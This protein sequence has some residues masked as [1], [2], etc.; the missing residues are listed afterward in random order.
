MR[1]EAVNCQHNKL[2]NSLCGY[3]QKSSPKLETIKNP[4]TYKEELTGKCFDYQ[5]K[6]VRMENVL[7]MITNS[8]EQSHTRNQFGFKD[9]H[10]KYRNIKG[11]KYQQW[12]YRK[13][14]FEEEKRKAKELGLKCRIIQGELYREVREIGA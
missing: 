10:E 13:E 4:V 9:C 1:C 6:A 12:T 5:E 7:S 11:V 2:D 3:C 8:N 14:E